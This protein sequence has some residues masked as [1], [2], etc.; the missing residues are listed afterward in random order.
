EPFAGRDSLE[1]CM[2]ERSGMFLSSDVSFSPA[3]RST[4]GEGNAITAAHLCGPTSAGDREG[5][6]PGDFVTLPAVLPG[7]QQVISDQPVE[8][9]LDLVW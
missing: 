8:E 5:N 4:A 2:H 9:F 1:P 3:E 7:S 6:V